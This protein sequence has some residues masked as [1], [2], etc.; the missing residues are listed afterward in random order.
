[1]FYAP[2]LGLLAVWNVIV[3]ALYGL[4][5]RRAVLQRRRTP[6]A[7]LI[8]CS[9]AGGGLGCFLGMRMFRHK[10]QKKAFKITAVFSIIITVLLA[11]WLFIAMIE[12]A[13]LALYMV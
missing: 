4:D 1:M 12:K 13:V 9:L 8:G 2:L 7:V 10:T 6:E 5:K 11:Y 3:F